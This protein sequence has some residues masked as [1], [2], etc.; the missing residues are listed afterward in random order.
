MLSLYIPISLSISI[1]ISI[2]IY[3]SNFFSLLGS[4]SSFEDDLQTSIVLLIKYLVR[5]C[6]SGEGHLVG[7]KETGIHPATLNMAQQFFPILLDEYLRSPHRYSLR[8]E[9]T[10]RELVG[11]H[12]VIPDNG[13]D[14]SLLHWGDT[15]LQH[16]GI[17]CRW[18]NESNQYWKNQGN[19]FLYLSISKY[20]KIYLYRLLFLSI[21]YSI[22]IYTCFQSQGPLYL[23]QPRLRESKSNAIYRNIGSPGTHLLYLFDGIH[24]SKVDYFYSQFLPGDFHSTGYAID[25]NHSRSTFEF[26]PR[27]GHHSYWTQTPDRD[28]LTRFH[29][30]QLS[31]MVSGTHGICQSQQLSV[32]IYGI[33]NSEEW[34]GISKWIRDIISSTIMNSLYSDI[35]LFIIYDTFSS[36]IPIGTFNKVISARGTRAYSCWSPSNPPVNPEY[37]NIPDVLWP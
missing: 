22:K 5:I 9:W 32:Y 7:P 8:H 36:G 26:A 24:I 35:A 12:V 23:P 31:S 30:S 37:P 6:N 10:N 3:L 15:L 28:G 29:F 14:S 34:D 1:S 21:R 11:I 16:N 18:R 27:R 25:S 19:S 4:H 17:I 2:S 20:I 13:Y 33:D